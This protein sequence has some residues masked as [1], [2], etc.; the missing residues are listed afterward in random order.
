V[1]FQDGTSTRRRALALLVPGA[2]AL[3]LATSAPAATGGTAGGGT[4]P[5]ATGGSAPSGGASPHS[6]GTTV[7]SR[8]GGGHGRSSSRRPRRAA[9]SILIAKARCV[10][11]SACISRIHYVSLGGYL[12]L[13]GRGLKP[14]MTVLFPHAFL[15]RISRLSPRARLA[16]TS[17]G[18][19]V[20]IPRAAHSGL[21][22]VA[23]AHG[24]HSNL[25]GPIHLVAR[26]L[27]TPPNRRPRP[28]PVATGAPG[29]SSAAGT[30]FA[31]LGMWIWELPKTDGGN[32]AAIAAQAKR[33]GIATLFVKS[34]DGAGYWSQFSPT[35][36]A[37][38]H[39][40]GLK[41]CAWQYVY[42]SNPIGEAE[43]GARA[44]ANGADCLVI[45]A[46]SEYE[47]H[48][49]AAQRYLEAL[50]AKIGADYPLGLTSFPY[51][52]YH[53]SFPYSVFLGPGGAQF[54]VPQ[55]YWKAIGISVSYAYVHTFQ[56]N[57]VYSRPICPLGQTYENP[58]AS[59]IVRFRSL[60]VPYQACGG[61]S[62]WDWQETSSSGWSALAAPLEEGL[63]IPQPELTSP[64]LRKGAKGDQ[65]LWLQEHLASAVPSQPTNGIFESATLAD[66][67]QFQTAHG[68][69]ASGE[70]D[71]STWAALLAL[72]PVAV[73]WTG[74]GP[75]G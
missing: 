40:E 44:V 19:V 38:M 39:A 31:G 14:G 42:G 69:A 73:N 7:R 23:G 34:S 64:L 24:R 48:Y 18:L 12:A 30:A 35:L 5:G 22:M 4:H 68:I 52:D 26:P 13:E 63:T 59:E 54:N 75:A 37:D 58:P 47:G 3:A 67:E 27:R 1:R 55:M 61:V 46:E 25:F 57:L 36:V 10:P 2:F 16:R 9:P 15:A 66:L 56:E 72:P 41:V 49:A 20:R 17:L 11:Q 28:R 71:P 6:G 45:D 53:E 60:A 21:I 29:P 8:S 74:G 65:V 43:A 70:T 51:V 33:T 32:L 62:F 50:R